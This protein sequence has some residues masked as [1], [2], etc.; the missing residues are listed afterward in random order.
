MKMR[1]LAGLICGACFSS[2]VAQ[3]ITIDLREKSDNV[4][5][6]GWAIG[7][8]NNAYAPTFQDIFDVN[9]KLAKRGNTEAALASDRHMW[10]ALAWRGTRNKQ[11]IGLK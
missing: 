5:R 1:L 11:F 8:A 6:P 4:C 2:C 3:T 10:K 7:T 9:Q